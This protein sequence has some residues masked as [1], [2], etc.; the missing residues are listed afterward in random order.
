MLRTRV[1]SSIILIIL[2]GIIAFSGN[3]ILAVGVFALAVIGVHEFYDSV[4]NAGYKPVRFLGYLLCTPILLIGFNGSMNRIGTYVE[5]FKSINYF[6]FTLFIVVVL[7]FST[8]I[9]LHDKY[10]IID[11]SLTMFGVLYVVFLFSFIV[12][13]RNLENG[14]FF[15]WI[16]FLGAWSTDTTAYFA[17]RFFGKHK[18]LPAISPKKTVEGGIGGVI[19]C[20]AITVLYGLYLNSYHLAYD[21]AITHLV[22]LGLLNGVIGQI[23]DWAAS[24]IKR[25]VKIKDYGSIMPGHGG[26]LD[27]FDSI[28]FIAPVV[29]FY[30][31]FII[32]K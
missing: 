14:L 32:L 23:G 31:S 13:T 30:I 4:S 27:R 28:L 10:N 19:G 26:I 18:L 22:I 29:Y 24:A 16:I 3:I 1:I 9:F 8:I 17:G 2:L 6:S 7:L 11:I 12:L 5:L 25:Y 15:I 20:V 21:I